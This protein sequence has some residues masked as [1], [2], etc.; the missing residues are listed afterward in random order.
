MTT[1]PE[2]LR[3]SLGLKIFIGVCL[4]LAIGITISAKIQTRRLQAGLSKDDQRL[5]SIGIIKR[6]SIG[7][8]AGFAIAV[9]AGA[10]QFIL[11]F[12]YFTLLQEIGVIFLGLIGAIIGAVCGVIKWRSA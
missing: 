8:L 10:A 3:N 11:R 12:G 5:K 6:L 9:L 2:Y 7:M 4:L 1:W